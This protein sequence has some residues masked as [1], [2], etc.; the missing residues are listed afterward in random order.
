MG[1]TQRRLNARP[2]DYDQGTEEISPTV[3]LG[4]VGEV[5]VGDA[6][7]DVADLIGFRVGYVEPVSYIA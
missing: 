3:T 2:Y 6:I 4:G 5:F 1:K 7:Q